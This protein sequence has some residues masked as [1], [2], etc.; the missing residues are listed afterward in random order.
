MSKEFYKQAL[1][2]AMRDISDLMARREK[3]E[4]E[5]EEIER[6]LMK[7]RAAAAS[8]ALLIGEDEA[9]KFFEDK[10]LFVEIFAPDVGLTNA[11]RKVLQQSSGIIGLTAMDVRRQLQ[12]RKFKLEKYQNVMA[13]IHTVLKRLSENDEVDVEAGDGGKAAYRWKKP[14]EEETKV[15]TD[16]E[17]VNAVV[18]KASK[19]KKKR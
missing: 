15:A 11:V 2:A 9:D 6:E 4:F 17:A 14:A 8:I 7:T 13:S 16:K 1:D 5:R 18:G 12:R 3:L 10:S 19:V